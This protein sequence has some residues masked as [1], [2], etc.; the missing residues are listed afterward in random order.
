ML[1]Y[2]IFIEVYYA[3]W[4][5]VVTMNNDIIKNAIV[6]F[7][8]FYDHNGLVFYLGLL[9]LIVII[10]L[11]MKPSKF[12]VLVTIGLLF[13]LF[14]FE[15]Q[16]HLIPHFYSHLLDPIVDQSTHARTYAYSSLFLSRLFPVILDVIGWSMIGISLIFT[17]KLLKENHA[18]ETSSK[19]L[20]LESPKETTTPSSRN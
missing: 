6:A 4:Y 19:I 18:K 20:D 11:F 17:E 15:Y 10:R 7:Y 9:F 16:K 13:L 8:A 12:Y 1:E 3:P 5:A 14:S 2:F